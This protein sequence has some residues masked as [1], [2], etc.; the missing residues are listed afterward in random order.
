MHRYNGQQRL[1]LQQAGQDRPPAEII[2]ARGCGGLTLV[3]ASRVVVVGTL[4]LPLLAQGR[5]RPQGQG[6]HG[7][8]GG[9]HGQVVG[10]AYSEVRGKT[11]R[12]ILKIYFSIQSDQSVERRRAKERSVSLSLSIQLG[13][14]V[15]LCILVQLSDVFF[16]QG[17]CLHPHRRLRGQGHGEALRDRERRLW[18]EEEGGGLA[19]AHG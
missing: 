1:R 18:R 3:P 5:R 12:K 16:P 17:L 6:A 10:I 19:Q 14:F 11:G 15:L 2:P 4:V 8:D 13:L 9:G 7:A